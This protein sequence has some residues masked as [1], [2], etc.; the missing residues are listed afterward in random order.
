MSDWLTL[1]QT[2][3]TGDTQITIT[4]STSEELYSRIARFRART[5]NNLTAD[6]AVN[7][8]GTA[9]FFFRGYYYVEDLSADNAPIFYNSY[10]TGQLP[11]GL[12]QMSVDGGP[13]VPANSAYTFSEAGWHIIDYT[14]TGTTEIP[15]YMFSKSNQGSQYQNQVRILYGV[16]IG[17]LVTGVGKFAFDRQDELTGVTWGS[18]LEYIRDGAFSGCD[19]QTA[20]LP[21]SVNFIGDGAFAANRNLYYVTL[22]SNLQ[23]L[24]DNT[25]ISDFG[26]FQDCESLESIVIPS[27][28]DYFAHSIFDG[29][30][31]LSSVTCGVITNIRSSAFRNTQLTQIPSI[32]TVERLGMA[33]FEGTQ[34][35]TLTI[36]QNILEI[37]DACFSGCSNLTS[38]SLI[39]Y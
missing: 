13:F 27:T 2:G 1:S 26:V 38:V 28:I 35:A 12:Y 21:E 36:P 20:V 7:Q 33:A 32:G 14:L 22:P 3:G 4:A 10:S 6:F 8:Y 34:I 18:N 17:D 9:S 37:G 31:S 19:I 24:G 23:V 39:L 11:S 5:P 25:Y 29:C 16:D 30:T 15:A